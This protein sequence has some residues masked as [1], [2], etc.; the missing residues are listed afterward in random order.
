MRRPADGLAYALSQAQKHGLT[1][2]QLMQRDNQ[3]GGNTGTEAG[4]APTRP[5]ARLQ[6]A[7]TGRD[8]HSS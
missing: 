7:T 6:R 4:A 2:E 3:N 8:R 5:K 1:Y